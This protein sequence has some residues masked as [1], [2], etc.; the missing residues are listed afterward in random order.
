MDRR[1]FAL[2][3]GGLAAVGALG[4]PQAAFAQKVPKDGE[5]YRTLQRPQPVIAPPGKIEVVD[6]F[7]Y[8]CPHCFA[9]EPRLVSWIKRQP[10][11]VFV[12][13]VPVGFRDSFVPQQRLFYTL[14]AMGKLD[15]LHQ[16]VFDAIHM[17]Q[18]P[19]DKVDSIVAFA[20]ANGLDRE[21]FLEL[22]NSF[23]ISSKARQATQLQDGYK[24][25]GVPALGVAG[26][27]YTDGELGHG[28]E[29][30][31]QVVDYLVAE[32]RKGR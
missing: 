26:R 5:D 25:D 13:R 6:F 9:F 15:E 20:Q 29:H 22:Y 7:W 18:Q 3:A 16:K 28:M 31:L 27:W 8:S 23:T 19:T 32:V 11:D 21:K 2:G 4:W 17:K 10:A 1:G 24:V 30:A 12:R 14:E